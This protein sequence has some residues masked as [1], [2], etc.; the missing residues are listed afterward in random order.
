MI[1]YIRVI[2]E[3]IVAFYGIVVLYPSLIDNVR[4]RVGS[5]GSPLAQCTVSHW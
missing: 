4:R 1:E 5:S 3:G 2:K